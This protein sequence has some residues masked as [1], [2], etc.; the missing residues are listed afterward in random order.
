MCRRRGTAEPGRGQKPRAIA[1][2]RSADTRGKAGPGQSQKSTPIARTIVNAFQPLQILNTDT[3]RRNAQAPEILPSRVEAKTREPL[4]A[5]DLRAPEER[6]S[7]VKAK[8]Q[9]P[10]RAGT[11]YM[12][13]RTPKIVSDFRK[14]VLDFP[15]WLLECLVGFLGVVGC[16]CWLVGF[17]C[18]L[19]GFHCWFVGFPCWF[20]G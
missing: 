13:T 1:C 3:R 5:Q 19:V 17:P 14:M 4:P 20:V 8:H 11:W 12:A 16:P 7:R 9:G 10:I 18:W 15:C 6:P 2:T